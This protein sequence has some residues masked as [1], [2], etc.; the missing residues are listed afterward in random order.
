M[1][2]KM[3]QRN[4]MRCVSLLHE[5]RRVGE[6]MQLDV[7]CLQEQYTKAGTI[8]RT[9]ITAQVAAEG[10]RPMATII[11]VKKAITVTKTSQYCSEHV[12]CVE[13]LTRRESCI[14]VSM[15]FQC[16][17]EIDEYLLRLKYISHLGQAEPLVYST[18]A[19]AKS[20]LWHS[21]LTDDCGR[22]LGEAIVELNLQPAARRVKDW[23][24]A[25][26]ITSS[27]HSI[28]HNAIIGREIQD[29]PENLRIRP[30]SKVKESNWEELRRVFQYPGSPSLSDTVDVKVHDLTVSVHRAMET[31]VHVSRGTMHLTRDA[32]ETE[33]RNKRGQGATPEN[34][35]P[36]R[37]SPKIAQ[38]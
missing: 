17:D 9:P 4:A 22:Q 26:R 33:K 31:S 32:A 36:R 12:I 24:T 30:K 16:S 3:G 19:N 29:T 10:Q 18:D 34:H 1:E 21:R 23:K 7:L 20:V 11:V 5:A 2:T 37:K 35:D 8:P 13:V 25:S 15:F 28:V 38:T 6:E 14:L 27:D